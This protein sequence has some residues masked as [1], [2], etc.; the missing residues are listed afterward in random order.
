M[1]LVD[2]VEQPLFIR[3]C[4]PEVVHAIFLTGMV[5]GIRNCFFNCYVAY[6]RAEGAV[7]AAVAMGKARLAALHALGAAE[8]ATRDSP[9]LAS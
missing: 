3:A 5:S 8:K 4:V 7:P 2:G 6:K 1:E 9:E